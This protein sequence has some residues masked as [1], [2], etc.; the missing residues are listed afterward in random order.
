MERLGSM[1]RSVW[2]ALVL[3]LALNILSWA[4]I[5]YSGGR[6]ANDAQTW[7]HERTRLL[8]EH[9]SLK[10]ELKN[11]SSA[12]T[13]SS[14]EA[15]SL[16][17]ELDQRQAAIAT[18]ETRLEAQ[19]EAGEDLEA[20]RLR[21]ASEAHE[22]EAQKAALTEQLSSYR[23][24][25]NLARSELSGKT[26][27]LGARKRELARAA[28]R[29]TL[30]GEAE[31]FEALLDERRAQA[32]AD[33]Q[34]YQH[35][36]N[37][38]R[39]ELSGKTATIGV[40][41]RE[42]AK[43]AKQLSF[44]DEAEDLE[45]AIIAER[46]AVDDRRAKASA[47]LQDYRQRI[48]LARSELSAKT[49]TIAA[50]ERELL[51]LA[52]QLSFVDEAEDLEAAII[53]ERQAV[54]ERR[55]KASAELQ[56][57][58]Q[59]TNLAR[60]E[61][62]GKTATIA[63]YERELAKLA[64]QLSFVD[65]AED[66]E[67]AIIAERQAVDERRAQA[68]ADL[69][70]YRQRINLARSELSGKAATIAARERELTKTQQQLSLLATEFAESERRLATL[71]NDNKAAKSNL[72][73]RT[74]ELGELEANLAELRIQRSEVQTVLASLV[75]ERQA[76]EAA[77]G[78]L[79]GLRTEIAS[80]STSLEA[81]KKE[82]AE[83]T[84][85]YSETETALRQTERTLSQK[86]EEIG[87]LNQQIGKGEERLVEIDRAASAIE[88]RAENAKERLAADG[89]EI[90]E[91]EKKIAALRREEEKVRIMIAGLKARITE[92]RQM[93]VDV[94]KLRSAAEE[95]RG[96]RD[97]QVHLLGQQQAEVAKTETR[98]KELETERAALQQEVQTLSTELVAKQVTAESLEDVEARLAEKEREL[99]G[100][101]NRQA[102]VLGLLGSL[103]AKIERQRGLADDYSETEERLA[104][105]RSDVGSVTG[106][107]SQR[108]SELEAVET[109]LEALTGSVAET[110]DQLSKLEAERIAEEAALA[111]RRSD[112]AALKGEVEALTA[113]REAK[114]AEVEKAEARFRKIQTKTGDVGVAESELAT[115]RSS[116]SAAE[117]DL[118]AKQESI[119]QAESRLAA[120]E[121]EIEKVGET[122]AD[123]AKRLK[124]LDSNIAAA[125]SA[126][127]D[128][129]GRKSTLT[130]EV[131][132]LEKAL[133]KRK[134]ELATA[135][136]ALT[137]ADEAKTDAES[138]LEQLH[139]ELESN[140]SVLEKT[141]QGNDSVVKEAEALE[142]S[143]SDLTAEVQKVEDQRDAASIELQSLQLD[144]EKAKV[145]LSARESALLETRAELAGLFKQRE[146]I[147]GDIETIGNGAVPTN[148]DPLL[149]ILPV[150]TESGVRIAHLLFNHSSA[151]LSPG[152]ERK[153]REAA[154]WIKEN[155]TKKV[156]LIGYADATGSR[157][158]NVRLS[159]A[160]ARQTAALLGRLGIERDTI[161]I[162][163]VGEDVLIE[164]TGNRV[165]EPL[166]RSVGIFVGE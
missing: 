81:G 64:K 58:R 51:K 15:T 94:D 162:E 156:R 99:S 95:A 151:E 26:A 67:A 126:L 142:A 92:Q 61:L 119:Q 1:P 107:L 32:S 42:L 18:L 8:G 56:S 55:A 127:E 66:L 43:L 46:Q 136:Q 65:E 104:A 148:V 36:I 29:L 69:Q 138:R 21:L 37:L 161:E 133:E 150:Q 14:D 3:L 134:A 20:I 62:S 128:L 96:E 31:D 23:E 4:I 117:A 12:L 86:R 144:V 59:R 124:E 147:A 84:A 50:H 93:E 79:E 2:G 132:T 53:A 45:A 82:L 71:R 54:D 34:D 135:E 116:L 108:R 164:A 47:E 141:R 159:E 145:D 123:Q 7:S 113:E 140:R 120:F 27:M 48:N 52:E 103:D 98:L 28:D 24:K 137:S 115:L 122:E 149:A 16:K 40:R 155:Q 129:G 25:V 165:A 17:N 11:A 152:A 30:L 163:A 102:N 97:E 6:H 100:L 39:S 91:S 83:T 80:V 112:V 73:S 106:A 74:K 121:T 125:N 114:R 22:A 33:L 85:R 166:N 131:D 38:A 77:R 89:R 41:E 49:A 9:A 143:L 19:R 109:R 68:S 5:A 160:R 88:S 111:E 10:D 157:E 139:A 90:A 154:T 35:R 118:Q 63:A 13:S 146:Q 158:A 70:G 153:V 87:D 72:D 44:V 75:Q 78:D 110:E 101:N 76:E 105:L 130:A 60:S 57:Y